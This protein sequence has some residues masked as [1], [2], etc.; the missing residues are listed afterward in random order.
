[1]LRSYQR[2][3]RPFSEIF[4]GNLVLYCE[5]KGVVRFCLFSWQTDE[6]EKAKSYLYHILLHKV[7]IQLIQESADHG[8]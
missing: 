5:G 3:I 7:E 2:L 1:M 8:T 6:F 4:R